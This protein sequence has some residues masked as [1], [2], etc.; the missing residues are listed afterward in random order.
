MYLAMSCFDRA[1][2]VWTWPP[3]FYLF[4]DYFGKGR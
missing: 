1:F 4:V 3:L 2:R